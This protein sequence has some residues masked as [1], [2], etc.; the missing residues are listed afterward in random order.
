MRVLKRSVQRKLEHI[1][2]PSLLSLAMINDFEVNL[3]TLTIM[4]L[5]VLGGLFLIKYGR[6]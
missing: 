5:P 3:F 4:F 2:V 6:Y 1:V